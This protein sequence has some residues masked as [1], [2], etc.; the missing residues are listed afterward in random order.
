M[1]VVDQSIEDA[2]ASCA[3]KTESKKQKRPTKARSRKPL[4]RCI[5]IEAALRS[6]TESLSTSQII[7]AASLA[8]GTRI[9]DNA[10]NRRVFNHI[11]QTMR[12]LD[13]C[14]KIKARGAAWQ[15]NSAKRT[16]VKAVAYVTGELAADT[17]SIDVAIMKCL[18]K[19]RNQGDG[20]LNASEITAIVNHHPYKETA[21]FRQS[22]TQNAHILDTLS[23]YGLI[24]AVSGSGWKWKSL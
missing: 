9:S 3:E 22:Q 8:G 20:V 13:L 14:V 4:N 17:K 15:W 12:H 7:E 5:L 16:N 2:L 6:Q 18:H 23:Y 1:S 21:A 10:D 24:S 19:A 11:L